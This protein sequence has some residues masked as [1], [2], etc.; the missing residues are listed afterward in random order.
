MKTS[1]LNAKVTFQTVT[2]FQYVMQSD[3]IQQYIHMQNV[4]IY[5]G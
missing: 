1:N 3:F 5:V 4:F 2:I